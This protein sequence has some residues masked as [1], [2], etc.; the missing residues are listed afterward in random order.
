MFLY[1]QPVIEKLFSATAA[2]VRSSAPVWGYVAFLL[3]SDDYASS[4]YVQKKQA[5]A[6]RCGLDSQLFADPTAS[7]ETVLS[8]IDTWN[9]DPL[10]LWIVVQLPLAAHLL[11][12]QPQIVHSVT[13]GKDVDGL[14]G[15]LFGLHLIELVTFLPATPKATFELLDFYGL[16]DLRGKVVTIIGQSNLMGKPCVVEA[17]RREATVTSC[18][19]FTDKS[20]LQARCLES[21]YI[22]T[23]TWVVWLL[24]PK[25]FGNQDLTGKVIIDVGY[26]IKD[27]KA[28]GDTD[29]QG[30]AAL[31]ATITPVP[32][33]V[34]PV[35]VATLFHNLLALEQIRTSG[36]V[37]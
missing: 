35:T 22:I 25:L 19:I 36:L 28:C 4:V 6:T 2:R 23:A 20:F 11:P 8:R 31:G 24:T 1:G 32:G 3:A 33:W 29:R 5:Y 18:N 16:G 21:D 9:A 7:Y 30:L 27:G 14:G 37:V 12:Y 34:G 10:C 13:P 26:G 17:L 15:E